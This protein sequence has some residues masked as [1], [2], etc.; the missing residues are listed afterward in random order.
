[1]HQWGRLSVWKAVRSDEGQEWGVGRGVGISVEVD[2]GPVV[3]YARAADVDGPRHPHELEVW[4]LLDE[5]VV[6]LPTGAG[7][8]GVGPV[9]AQ[10]GQ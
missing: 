2:R 9:H 1:M 3:G 6:G 4:V 10:P 5:G 7:E 8:L